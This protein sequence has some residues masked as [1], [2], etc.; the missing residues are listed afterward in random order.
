[1]AVLSLGFFAPDFFF[2]VF[3]FG[4]GVCRRF[5]FGAGD[6][7]GLGVDAARVSVSSD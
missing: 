5:V 6:F 1:L 4:V 7:F 2:G 3:G